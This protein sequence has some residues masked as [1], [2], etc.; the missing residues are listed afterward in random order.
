[1]VGFAYGFTY[2]KEVD[3]A[4]IKFLDLPFSECNE[5]THNLCL[6]LD[7]DGRIIGLEILSVSDGVDINKLPTEILID[8]RQAL[9]SRGF[10]LND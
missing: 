6:D 9:E 1:M 2:D 8:V 10:P 5:I 3:A 7:V 4:Y